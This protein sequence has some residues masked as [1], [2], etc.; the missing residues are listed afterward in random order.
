MHPG[1]FNNALKL[2]FKMEGKKNVASSGGTKSIKKT[3]DT[4]EQQIFL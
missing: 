1:R 2:Y 4:K 3:A